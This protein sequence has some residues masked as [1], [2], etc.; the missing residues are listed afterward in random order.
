MSKMNVIMHMPFLVEADFRNNI[1]CKIRRYRDYV[2][3][4][5]HPALELLDD[6]PI[7]QHQ[8]IAIKGLQ[9]HRKKIGANMS[10]SISAEPSGD[11]SFRYSEISDDGTRSEVSELR[12]P[13][14]LNGNSEASPAVG[15]DAGNTS[16]DEAELEGAA[17]EEQSDD[18]A[19][20]HAG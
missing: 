6:Q 2:I 13:D 3:G 17:I 7:P 16:W 15:N 12:D 8:Q 11:E 20:E 10:M 18:D 14:E 19:S 5:A 1:C 4:V 9:A